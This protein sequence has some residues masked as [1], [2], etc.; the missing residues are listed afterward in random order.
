MHQKHSIVQNLQ[1]VTTCSAFLVITRG[2][3]EDIAAA[4]GFTITTCFNQI[5]CLNSIIT[6]RIMLIVCTRNIIFQFFE[7]NIFTI[8]VSIWIFVLISRS[9]ESVS[10]HHH[11]SQGICR[12]CSTK[13]GSGTKTDGVRTSST[14]VTCQTETIFIPIV[15]I[16]HVHFIK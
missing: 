2:I 4:E 1:N 15:L 9:K 8:L 5:K 16:R 12:F 13:C 10:Y 14:R 11:R 6:S 3:L 7:N